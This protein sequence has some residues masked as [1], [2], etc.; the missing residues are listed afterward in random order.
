MIHVWNIYHTINGVIFFRV[1]V[2]KYT[3][4]ANLL[5]VSVRVFVSYLNPEEF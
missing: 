1:N 5:L 2:G 3:I 4:I